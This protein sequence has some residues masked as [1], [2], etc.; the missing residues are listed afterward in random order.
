MSDGQIKRIERAIE[1]PGGHTPGQRPQIHSG[2]GFDACI[3]RSQCQQQIRMQQAGDARYGEKERQPEALPEHADQFI[4]FAGSLELGDDRRH[5]LYHAGQRQHHRYVNA[6]A[7]GDNN[8]V[9]YNNQ[10]GALRNLDRTRSTAD[11]V[12]ESMLSQGE[13]IQPTLYKNQGEIIKIY[14]ARD[15][16]FSQVYELTRNP[17]S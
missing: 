2:L 15:V 8:T 11:R 9:Y 16:D 12:V 13:D 6:A 3:E 17:R 4:V 10:G 5:C 1:Q 14:I 7:N